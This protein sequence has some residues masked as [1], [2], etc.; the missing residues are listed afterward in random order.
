MIL[1]QNMRTQKDNVLQAPNHP[2]LQFCGFVFD[3]RIE[4]SVGVSVH[5]TGKSRIFLTEFFFFPSASE[6][7]WASPSPDHP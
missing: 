6:A 5:E 1:T 7:T 3:I 2:T 4:F